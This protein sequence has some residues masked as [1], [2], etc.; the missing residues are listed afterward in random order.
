MKFENT[1]RLV[2]LARLRAGLTQVEFA[3]VLGYDNAQVVSNVER[4]EAALPAKRAK[5]IRALLSKESLLRAYMEDVQNQ[6]RRDYE[7]TTK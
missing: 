3:T 1:A 6:W 4:G 5:K 2:R 7:G